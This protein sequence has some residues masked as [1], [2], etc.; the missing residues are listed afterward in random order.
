MCVPL[1]PSDDVQGA[2]ALYDIFGK[3]DQEMGKLFLVDVSSYGALY[4]RY[5][6]GFD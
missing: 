2:I 3:K 4:F 1:F 5:M 6:T